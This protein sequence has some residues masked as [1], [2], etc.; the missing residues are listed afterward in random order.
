MATERIRDCAQSNL[1]GSWWIHD[2][3]DAVTITWTGRDTFWVING[4][5]ARAQSTCRA[6][7]TPLE[8]LLLGSARHGYG[9]D[10]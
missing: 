1:I 5:C 6:E 7:G 2:S 9:E 4:S 10:T 3:D 8:R